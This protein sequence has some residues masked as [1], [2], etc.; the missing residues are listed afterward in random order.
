MPIDRGPFNALL[1][2]DG[3]NTV[4][5]VWN[6]A[7]IQSVLLDPIDRMPWTLVETSATGMQHNFN[8]GFNGHTLLRCANAAVL[9]IT[10]FVAGFEGQQIVVYQDSAQRVDLYPVNGGSAVAG[11]LV[12]PCVSGPVSLQGASAI[13][14]VAAYQY[15]KGLWRLR[16]H[17]QGAWIAPGYSGARYTAPGGSWTVEAA[18]EAVY[19]YRVQGTLLYLSVYLNATSVGGSPG[20]LKVALPSTYTIR[21][22]STSPIVLASNGINELG[23]AAMTANGT[24]VDLARLPANPFVATTNTTYVYFLLAIPIN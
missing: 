17:E 4:G 20:N 12:H 13:N 6:K 10:G 19:L 2:D 7:Q 24:T 5:T 3:S 23:F 14:G 22:Q 9:G 16:S 11:Q 18:D 15:S 21:A 8:P 1:D